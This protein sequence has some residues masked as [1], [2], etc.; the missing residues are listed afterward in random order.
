M[1][2][3]RFTG[4]CRIFIIAHLVFVAE[5]HSVLVCGIA[6]VCLIACMYACEKE[7]GGGCVSRFAGGETNKTGQKGKTKRAE[8][9]RTEELAI[10]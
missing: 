2:H 3:T 4:I 8:E 6:F 5:N 7:S 10:V 1:S 9:S